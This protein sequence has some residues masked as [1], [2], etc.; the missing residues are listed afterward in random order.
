MSRPLLPDL[1]VLASRAAD[2]AARPPAN[3]FDAGTVRL[4]LPERRSSATF[5]VFAADPSRVQT[6]YDPESDRAVYLL[7]RAAHPHVGA[8]SLI[9][10]CARTAMLESPTA[11]RELYGHFVILIEDRARQQIS[12]V[13]DVLG[14]RPWFVGAHDG[15]LVAGSDVL[16]ICDAG[17]S[18]GEINYDAVSC[19]LRYNQELLGASIV[20][21]YHNLAPGSISTFDRAGRMIGRTCYGCF[22]VDEQVVGQEQLVDD[23]HERVSRAFAALTRDADEINLPLSGGFD[24]RYLAALSARGQSQRRVPFRLTTIRTAAHE[25]VPAQRVAD[26]LGQ[27][28]RIL[29]IDRHILDLFDDP[30]VFGPAGFPTGRNLTSALARQQ[31][32]VPLLSGFLG[33]GLMRASLTQAGNHYFDLEQRRASVEEM[34]DAAD[35]RYRLKINR[36]DLLGSTVAKCVEQ[37]AKRTLACVLSAAQACG[38]PQTYADIYHRQRFY[39]ANIFLQHLDATEALIPFASWELVNYRMSHA[40]SCYGTNTYQALFR[41]HFPC[42]A[43]IPHSSAFEKTS[44]SGIHRAFRRPT[45]HLR[46]WS[47]DLLR[48]ALGHPATREL[49]STCRFRM[50]SMLPSGLLAEPQY[51]T[52]IIFLRKL[53]AFEQRLRAC[54]LRLDWNAI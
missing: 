21:D 18:K 49:A 35:R 2:N 19:W 30:I 3:P 40:R 6:F 1:F 53:Q 41:R 43:D 7:G 5:H 39:F 47:N 52:E 23:L 54:D 4:T 45:R 48:S 46:R 20:L 36:I 13:S 26:A 34:T 27:P 15:R 38:K 17:L 44:G 28:L 24:S 32:G 12:F 14:V 29:P 37:R 8:S 51:Q 42:L 25:T 16:S 10:W 22:E 11:L 33:D 31:P 9:E 50:L